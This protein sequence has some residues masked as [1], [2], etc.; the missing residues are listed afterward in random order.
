[1][2]TRAYI[3]PI[4]TFHHDVIVFQYQLLRD[5]LASEQRCKQATMHLTTELHQEKVKCHELREKWGKS[6]QQQNE[7]ESVLQACTLQNIGTVHSMSKQYDD[8]M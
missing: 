2:Y 5:T 6:K 8:L 4:I 3:S 7:L 1:M